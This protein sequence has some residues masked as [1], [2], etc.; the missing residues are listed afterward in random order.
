MLIFISH[1]VIAGFT[2]AAALIIG[3]SQ[4]SKIPGIKLTVLNNYMADLGE[5]Y[6]LVTSLGKTH[7]P[8]LIMGISAIIIIGLLKKVFT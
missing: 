4:V 7:I 2:N 8:T 5:C 1:L 6:E 3:F